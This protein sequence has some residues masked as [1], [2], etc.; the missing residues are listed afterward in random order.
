MKTI[1]KQLV[2]VT[3]VVLLVA[4]CS[5]TPRTQA[6]EYDTFISFNKFDGAHLN[7]L[8][9]DGWVLVGF[10]YV[11]KSQTGGMNDEYYYVFKRHQE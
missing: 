7:S 8:G 4:G 11:P 2:L 3:S 5:T 1:T 9:K 6:W 10:T